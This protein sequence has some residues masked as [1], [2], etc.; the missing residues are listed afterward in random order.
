MSLL[1]LMDELKDEFNGVVQGKRAT[2]LIKAISTVCHECKLMADHENENWEAILDS[3]EHYE[4]SAI[5]RTASNEMFVGVNEGHIASYDFS[6]Y[7]TRSDTAGY[8]KSG[9]IS[10]LAFSR[11]HW[12]TAYQIVR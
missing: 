7:D 11:S 9:H 3:F 4:L 1:G 5:R 2:A 10:I 6:W 8:Q 12:T